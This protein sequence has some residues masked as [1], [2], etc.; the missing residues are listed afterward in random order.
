MIREISSLGARGYVA[1]TRAGS[2]LVDAVRIV[3]AGDTFFPRTSV[4][5]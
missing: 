2:D 1:K 4:A 5:S 3:L